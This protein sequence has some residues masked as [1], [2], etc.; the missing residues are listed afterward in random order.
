M[1]ILGNRVLRREDP[2]L[3]TGGGTYVDDV[4][5][6]G[7]AH[8]VYVRS[9]IAHARIESIDTTEAAAAPGVLAVVTAADIDLPRLAPIGMVNQDM[10]RPVLFPD[11]GTNVAMT[12]DHR[13]DPISFDGCEVVVTTRTVNQRLAPA[14]IEARSALAWWDDDD[15]LV[16]EIGC[17]GPHPVRAALAELYGLDPERV[18]VICPDVGGGFGAKAHAA[19]EALLLGELARRLGRPVRW[20]E[21]RSENLGS[22]VN[23]GRGQV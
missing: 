20:S 10:A 7:A 23:H 16:L 9:T 21:T 4:A 8:V 22:G 14:P 17:Q 2:A 15:R 18:R 19:P 5:S 3:L 1:S 12:I 6:P 13:S 11:A